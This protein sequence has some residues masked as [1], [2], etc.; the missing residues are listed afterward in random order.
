MISDLR[1]LEDVKRVKEANWRKL[2]RVALVLRPQETPSHQRKLRYEARQRGMR[3][4]YLPRGMS[5]SKS[6][7]SWFDYRRGEICW[8]IDWMLPFSQDRPVLHKKR[9]PETET[10][11][12]ALSIALD[13]ARIRRSEEDRFSVVMKK[14]GC[15]A[16]EVLHFDL[17]LEATLRSQLE[18]KDLVE[19][20][21]LIVLREGDRSKY[22]IQ[23]SV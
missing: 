23:Q 14:A 1:L 7:S 22:N 17:D 8:D 20:P 2:R 11:S 6:N 10:V 13:T 18:G 15:P 16:N 19:Y 12:K 9:V 4:E 3:L 21:V 5:R